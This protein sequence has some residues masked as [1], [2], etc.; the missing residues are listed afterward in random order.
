LTTKNQIGSLSEVLGII[1]DQGL[2]LT[3]IQSV[4]IPNNLSQ[5]AFHLDIEFNNRERLETALSNLSD[6]VKSIKTLGLYK[7]QTIPV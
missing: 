6:K 4:P 3:K 5:Y 1:K 7:G 2:N